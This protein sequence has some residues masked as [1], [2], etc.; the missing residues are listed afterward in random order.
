MIQVVLQPEPAGFNATVRAPGNHFL[1]NNPA[2]S[3]REIKR[4][5]ADYWRLCLPQLRAAYREICAYS[6]VWIPYSTSVDHFQPRSRFHAL[7]YEWSNFRLSDQKI[8]HRKADNIGV[9]DPFEVQ[10]GWFVIDF[11]AFYVRCGAGLQSSDEYRVRNTI[12]LLQLNDDQLVEQRRRV[13]EEYA[14][15]A[16]LEDVERYYPFVASEL[17]RQNLTDAIRASFGP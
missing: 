1:A 17:R 12:S 10:P 4:A 13:V 2:P 8:N 11:A 7:A 3:N 15:G 6:A 5:G 14:R 16:P 9:Q